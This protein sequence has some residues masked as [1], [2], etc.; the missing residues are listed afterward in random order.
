M[1]HPAGPLEVAVYRV[2]DGRLTE[3]WFYPDEPKTVD[4]FWA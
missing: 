1:W 4:A 2:R 3:A